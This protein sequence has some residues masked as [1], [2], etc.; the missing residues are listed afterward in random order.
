MSID[1]AYDVDRIVAEL[2][3][4]PAGLQDPYPHYRRL[5]EQGVV[6]RTGVG[7]VD[8]LVTGY[9]AG[10]GV[11][12]DPRVIRAADRV[13][14]GR[15]DRAEHISE[16]L[17]QRLMHRTDPP[18]HTRLRRLVSK[19]FTPR[20]VA[21]QQPA[22]EA[23][24]DDLLEP[25][26]Q[27]AAAG[28][29]VDL[30]TELALPL[31][32]AVIGRMV[33]VP[34][35]D[36]QQF[37]AIVRDFSYAVELAIDAH[38]L[39]LADAAAREVITYFEALIAE[40]RRHPADDLTSALVAVHESGDRLT[41]EELLA[42]LVLLFMAGFE[43]TT[44]LIGNGMLALLEHPDQLRALRDN[45][46]GVPDA[47]EE[48]LRYDSPVQFIAGFTAE[49]VVLADG[50][51][52][53]A[54]H[55]ILSMI[56]AANHDPR[57]FTRPERLQLDRTEA[58]PASFGGGIHYCLGSGLARLEGRLAFS[59]LLTRFSAIELAGPANRRQGLSVRGLASLPLQLTPAAGTGRQAAR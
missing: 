7:W 20:T 14:P 56:G 36:W 1:A 46:D 55:F 53:P 19:A 16:A 6:H 17:L 47:V 12:R 25:I 54:D 39:A 43:T 37:Q 33:G 15:P 38:D 58:P 49:P 59:E 30:V 42:T 5:H 21:G 13:Q 27:R 2:F 52:V 23:V 48:L 8:W 40:R 18:D 44:H 41:E 51:A 57:V 26:T 31:P 22:I 35:A 50:T 4:P 45:P 24:L 11:L 29:Q 10:N 9:H 32:I 3:T 28:E 34:A